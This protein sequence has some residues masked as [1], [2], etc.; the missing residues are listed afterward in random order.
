MKDSLYYNSNYAF[1]PRKPLLIGRLIWNTI[2]S[3]LLQ[4]RVL[5]YVDVSISTKC[6][7]NCQHCFAAAFEYAEGEQLTLD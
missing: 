3:K 6:N 1:I 7:L 5:R 2:L 4:K